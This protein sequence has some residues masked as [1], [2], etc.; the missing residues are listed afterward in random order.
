MSK[1]KNNRSWKNKEK[2]RRAKFVSQLS[3]IFS[4][5]KDQVQRALSLKRKKSIRIN[6][7]KVEDPKLII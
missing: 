1:Y 3:Q 2:V 6:T 5:S 4:I 7:L